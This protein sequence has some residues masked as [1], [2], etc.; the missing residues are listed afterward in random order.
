MYKRQ[1]QHAKDV[2]GAVDATCGRKTKSVIVTEN[3]MIVLSALLPETIAQ[4][5][6]NNS[7]IR[8]DLND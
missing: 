8:G 6:N 3:D 5:I 7:G 4:R 2:G 1:I